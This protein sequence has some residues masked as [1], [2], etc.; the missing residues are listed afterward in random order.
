MAQF[1]GSLDVLSTRVGFN[2]A[3]R[4]IKKTLS[5]IDI[6]SENKNLADILEAT[7]GEDLT[8]E[9]RPIVLRMLLADKM[10][11]KTASINLANVIE[12]SSVLADEFS[13]WKAVDLVIAYYHP[14]KGILMANPKRKESLASLG[15]L[16]KHELLVVFAGKMGNLPMSSVK[17]QPIL[18]WQCSRE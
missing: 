17:R 13:R 7:E 9:Q 10:G 4:H 3:V 14:D 18:P 6:L 16:K 11:Y 5:I 15:P 1:A 12:D 8:N 2:T